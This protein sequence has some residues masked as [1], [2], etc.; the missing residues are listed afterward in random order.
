MSN[1]GCLTHHY[2]MRVLC[3]GSDDVPEVGT[4]RVP[5]ERV[6]EF[7]VRDRLNTL[8]QRVAKKFAIKPESC[9]VGHVVLQAMADFPEGVNQVG[10]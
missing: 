1:F 3:C 7:I 4:V 10:L 5:T 6:A 2:K 8:K 9:H